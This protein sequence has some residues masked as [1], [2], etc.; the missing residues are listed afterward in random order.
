M[1]CRQTRV[2]TQLIQHRIAKMWV[3]ARKFRLSSSK[4]VASLRIS[5]IRQKKRSGDFALGVERGVVGDRVSGRAPGRDDGE[6]ALVCDGLADGSAVVG[7]VGDDGERGRPDRERN[8]K[9]DIS[10]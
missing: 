10:Q 5:L 7:L 8:R 3:M 9:R 4:R 2:W 6:G 1:S